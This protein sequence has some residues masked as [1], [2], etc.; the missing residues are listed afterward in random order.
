MSEEQKEDLTPAPVSLS[1]MNEDPKHLAGRLDE[2]A[3]LSQERQPDLGYFVELE[4][5]GKIQ[6]LIQEVRQNRPRLFDYFL[7]QV[8]SAVNPRWSEKS[9]DM[10][11]ELMFLDEPDLKPSTAAMRVMGTIRMP[12]VMKGMM[13]RRSQRVKHRLRKRQHDQEARN[14]R[15]GES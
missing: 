3:T 4:L 14:Q 1:M 5:K 6:A 11:L 9:Y 7:N 2:Y 12:L 8:A 13:V 10:R 15:K